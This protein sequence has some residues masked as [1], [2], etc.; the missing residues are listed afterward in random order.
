MLKIDVSDRFMGPGQHQPFVDIVS[1]SAP[2]LCFLNHSA[3]AG[4]RKWGSGT[5]LG[6]DSTCYSGNEE[7]K[8]EARKGNEIQKVVVRVGGGG[9]SHG[10]RA[11]LLLALGDLGSLLYFSPLRH[12]YIKLLW[13]ECFLVLVSALFKHKCFE[14]HR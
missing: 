7:K 8:K 1:V 13:A 12:I 2:G 14:V 4:Q 10:V 6:D 5:V 11:P 3:E 9:S